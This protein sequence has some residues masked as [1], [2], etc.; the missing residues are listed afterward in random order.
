V[1]KLAIS[2]LTLIWTGFCLAGTLIAPLT[3]SS[4]VQVIPVNGLPSE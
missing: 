3:V 4:S 1:A 2:H